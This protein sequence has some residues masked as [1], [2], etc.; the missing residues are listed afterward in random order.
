VLRNHIGFAL[1]MSLLLIA[2]KIPLKISGGVEGSS[3][4]LGLAGL[5][6]WYL[7]CPDKLLRF[8]RLRLSHPLSWL[9][10][11]A[12]YALILSLL[13]ANTARIAYSVQYLLYVVMG[14]IL[15]KR[16]GDNISDKDY[17]RLCS[18]LSLIALVYGIGIVVSLFTGPIYPHQVRATLR[19]W[20]GLTIQ[21]GVGF[22]ESQ[23]MAGPVVMF[24]AAACIYLY[25]GKAWKK[26]ILLTLLL[27]A[28]LA[29]LSRGAIV[30]FGVALCFVYWL[31]CV[32]PFVRRASLKVSVLKNMGFVVLTFGFLLITLI[33]AIHL[34]NKGLLPAT[35]AGLG[36]THQHSVVSTDMAAR[37]NLWTWGLDTWASGNLL[38]MVFGGGFR[39]SM[40]AAD[41]GAW[42]DAHNVYI[43]I[44]GDFGVIGLALFIGALSAAFFR[45]TR[46]FLT[47]KA[48]ALEKFGL[49]VLLGLSI[50][51]MTGPYFY[52]PVCLSLLIFTLAV[53][54]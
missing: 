3:V 18:I 24:F 9:I 6:L 39:S 49:L 29:T 10:T 46:L 13:S 36:L 21:Q 8:P 44:L 37:F 22:A 1:F 2:P 38:R 41:Y 15:V 28:L 31:D 32:E 27:S 25:R 4:S 43:T 51:N 42:R 23:N 20:E 26:W 16:Y 50:D 14:T 34:T 12:V 45:Y 35:L 40:V 19:R 33:V 7:A 53:T 11:F 5:V 47:G 48:G 54:L 17:D 30:S 52:S